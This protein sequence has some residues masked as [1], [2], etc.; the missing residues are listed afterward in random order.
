[1]GGARRF[2]LLKKKNRKGPE[3]GKEKC[4]MNHEK[5]KSRDGAQE[6]KK[7]SEKLGVTRESGP[8]RRRVQGCTKKREKRGKKPP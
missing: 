6:A 8:E 3:R 5:K 7:P 4:T 1:M 2:N